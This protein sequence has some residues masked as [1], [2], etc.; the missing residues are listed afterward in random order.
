MLVVVVVVLLLIMTVAVAEAVVMGVVVS[1]GES[2]GTSGD[3]GH[4]NSKKVNCEII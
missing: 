1:D 2:V 4:S 3:S